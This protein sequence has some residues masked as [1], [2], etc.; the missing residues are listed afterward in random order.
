VNDLGPVERV[1]FIGIGN[2]GWPMA[3]N[4]LAAGLE[5]TVFDVNAQRCDRFVQEVGGRLARSATSAVR[6]VDVVV[7]SL[8]T[9]EHVGTVLDE[10]APVLDEG[11]VVVDTTSGVPPRTRAMATALL[12]RGVHLVDCPVSGGVARALNGD[13]AIM[14]GGE[15]AELVRVAPVLR[16]IGSSVHRCGGVGSG[17]AMKALNNLVSAA[18]LLATVEA[19]LIGTQFGLDANVMVDVLNASSGMNNSTKN[20]IRQFV[21]SERYDSGFGLDLMVKDIGIALGVGDDVG[22]LTPFS[23]TCQQLWSSA[24]STLGSGQDHTAIAR[25]S[26][27]LAGRRL[28]D[29]PDEG[30]ER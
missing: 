23:A 17:Q 25:F 14:A 16:A 15:D 21:L 11:V 4:L 5:V 3:A 26:E 19:L 30:H 20:K 22:V 6:G 28:A 13:L 9:S 2:M 24:A 10:V 7:T 1:A 18:G 27:Q 29:V 12:S 8:P